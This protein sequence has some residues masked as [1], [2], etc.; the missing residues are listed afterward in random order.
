MGGK[1]I[2]RGFTMLDVAAVILGAAIASIHVR[3][4]VPAPHG[5]ATWF[6]GVALFLWLSLTA[7]GPFLYL[8][9]RLIPR[10]GVPWPLV[11]DRLWVLWGCPWVISAVVESAI[12]PRA[13]ATGQLEPI[14][15]GSLGLGLFLAT[16]I[17]LPVLA[18]RYLWGEPGG[19][20]RAAGANWTQWVGLG[21]SATWPIQCGV[22]LVLMG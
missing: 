2:S 12:N 22:G 21:L 19:V 4:A 9:R 11:G 15:V 5:K 16:T 3:L 6:F 17:A 10:T 8:S 7:T 14:Y 13:S 20:G 1:E 18:A